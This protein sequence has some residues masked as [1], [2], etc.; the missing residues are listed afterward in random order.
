MKVTITLTREIIDV[1]EGESLYTDVR[2]YLIARP[3]VKIVA[4]ITNNITPESIFDGE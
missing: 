1:R 4:H 2:E 3:D